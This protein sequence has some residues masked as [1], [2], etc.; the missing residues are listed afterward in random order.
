MAV[1]ARTRGHLVGRVALDGGTGDA[2]LHG[3]E[4]E[5]VEGGLVRESG[6]EVVDVLALHG[7]AVENTVVPLPVRRW[8]KPSQSSVIVT[9][10]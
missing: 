1:G 10:S 7:G 2:G 8:P 4:H 5:L 9:P 3:D 6:R